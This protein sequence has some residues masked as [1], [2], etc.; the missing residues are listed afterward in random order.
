MKTDQ[1]PMKTK[2]KIWQ[3]TRINE[4]QTEIN[5]YHQTISGHES[6]INENHK[7]KYNSNQ[8]QPMILKQK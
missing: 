8:T 4:T 5:E 6:K 3:S 2:G 1:K 7:N